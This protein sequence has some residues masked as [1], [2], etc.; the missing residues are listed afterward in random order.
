MR[1]SFCRLWDYLY[2][3]FYSRDM[4]LCTT[5]T[6][7]ILQTYIT[8]NANT[9]A[10]NLNN[11]FD[12]CCC[13]CCCYWGLRRSFFQINRSRAYRNRIRS[14]NKNA[15]ENTE[16][17]KWVDCLLPNKHLPRRGSPFCSIAAH[18]AFDFVVPSWAFVRMYKPIYHCSS[19]RVCTEQK[20]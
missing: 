10:I 15:M 18:V 19:V 20:K 11:I 12:V 3:L 7:T 4:D 9:F 1:W 16:K 17:E 13:R 8:S 14:D 2:G 6:T 5:T